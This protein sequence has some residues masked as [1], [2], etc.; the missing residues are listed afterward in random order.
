MNSPIISGLKMIGKFIL[1]YIYVVLVLLTSQL[2]FFFGGF[3][4]I[5]GLIP[6]ILGLSV[7]FMM[8][9]FKATK[10]GGSCAN[11]TCSCNR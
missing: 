7:P 9:Y 3:S 10:K 8:G 5:A 4:I 11:K 1:A 2:F 6:A